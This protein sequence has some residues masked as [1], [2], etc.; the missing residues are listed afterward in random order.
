MFALLSFITRLETEKF[1]FNDDDEFEAL[2]NH[3]YSIDLLLKCKKEAARL[4]P[5]TW[6]E[7]EAE[8][9]LPLDD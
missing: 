1:I 5:A 8:L 3:L 2:E 4:S 7:I 6:D 9:L